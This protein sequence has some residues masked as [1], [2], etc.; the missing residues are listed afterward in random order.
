[1]KPLLNQKQES[2]NFTVQ[3]GTK[4]SGSISVNGAKNS[5][6]GIL[7]ASL[8]NKG[9][10]TLHNMPRIEEVSRILEVFES[11]GVTLKWISNSSLEIRT[12][13]EFNLEGINRLSATKT[14]SVIMM[15]GALLFQV[16]E[17]LIPYSGGCKLGK[18]T[19][20]PH[21]SMLE[22]FGAQIEVLTKDYKVS[23][24]NEGLLERIILR[25]RGDTVT[26]NAIIAAALSNREIEIRFGTSN[27][28]VSDTAK[29]LQKLGVKITGIGTT[30]YRVKGTKSI[31]R[32]ISYHIMEDPIEAI[33]FITAAIITKSEITVE[34]CPLDYI[35]FE[36]EKLKEMGLE[37]NTL[38]KYK[39][40][41]GFDLVD[42]KILGKSKLKTV[43]DAKIECQPFPH[44]NADSL[45]F[46]ALI[47]TQAKGRTLIHDWMYENRAIYLTELSK[48]G[49]NVELVDTHRVFISGPTKFSP[50]DITSPPA[51]R[52]AVLLLFAMMAAPKNETSILRNIYSIARG[53]EDFANRLNSI[54]AKITVAG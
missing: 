13:K 32:N 5:A 38:K 6:M 46:F 37:F 25:E 45:P 31:N 23:R 9:I 39:S 51:L 30:T 26:E 7:C 33:S 47:C 54:G 42:L 12:P 44:L 14:R 50:A 40:R 34:K 2:L 4:L 22:G 24:T 41:E 19:I 43:I 8:L 17:F 48:L 16:D 11:I 49:A 52:P 27:Y 15:M 10:T 20:A 21:L 53:Y 35:E 18:R 36:L 28:M 3:G 29:F 1:M